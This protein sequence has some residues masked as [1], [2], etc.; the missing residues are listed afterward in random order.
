MIKFGPEKS[1]GSRSKKVV[2]LF[3]VYSVV[4]TNE[5]RKLVEDS[6]KLREIVKVCCFSTVLWSHCNYFNALSRSF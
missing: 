6:G 5:L 1:K 4:S 3:K 2:T